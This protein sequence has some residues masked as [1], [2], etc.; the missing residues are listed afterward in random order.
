MWDIQ[1]SAWEH[2]SLFS[3]CS[4]HQTVSSGI[5]A[6][7]WHLLYAQ[8][9]L[10]FVRRHAKASS[11]MLLRI[12]WTPR[13]HFSV[14]SIVICRHSR[15][16]WH[17]RSYRLH[18]SFCQN[19]DFNQIFIWNNWSTFQC[20]LPLPVP[21]FCDITL[22]KD[23]YKDKDKSAKKTQRVLYFW[24]AEGSRISITTSRCQM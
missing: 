4:F 23:K 1:A 16:E 17:H 14:K 13:F 8:L 15:Q 9:F 22:D 12:I 24:E 18:H 2:I 6:C 19:W 7:L 11:A 10:R 3:K 5:A 20:F 21:P